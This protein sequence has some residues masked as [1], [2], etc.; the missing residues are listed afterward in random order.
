L[1]KDTFKYFD[2]L[3]SKGEYFRRLIVKLKLNLIE[4]KAAEASQ[5]PDLLDKTLEEVFNVLKVPLCNEKAMKRLVELRKESTK[6]LK[7]MFSLLQCPAGAKYGATL[8]SVSGALLVNEFSLLSLIEGIGEKIVLVMSEAC[9]YCPRNLA[10]GHD[11]V[12]SANDKVGCGPVLKKNSSTDV[13]DEI[14]SAKATK[15]SKEDEGGNFKCSSQ[16]YK[17]VFQ[18]F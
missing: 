9:H 14:D 18:L 7:V 3:N 12:T 13:T 10:V 15:Q 1:A 6:D 2:G 8:E 11:H 5:R 17:K 16:Y 4:A